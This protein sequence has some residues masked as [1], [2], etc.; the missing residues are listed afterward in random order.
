M[1]RCRTW[2]GQASS[3][4]LPTHHLC[5]IL[6]PHPITFAASST[7]SPFHP[8]SYSAPLETPLVW[9]CWR[10]V[11]AATRRSS[12]VIIEVEA[13]ALSCSHSS[14]LPLSVWR[15]WRCQICSSVWLVFRRSS[16]RLEAPT[17]RLVCSCSTTVSIEFRCT[18]CSCSQAR[19]LQCLSRQNDSS[20]SAFHSERDGISRYV[21]STRYSWLLLVLNH[22][23]I[24]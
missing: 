20:P 22:H 7:A 3:T 5:I 17:E 14:A 9:P 19:G 12:A 2:T 24:C 10:R 8:C 21:H 15:R 4:T 18:I 11:Q 16:S 1:V 13:A 23:L 6:C